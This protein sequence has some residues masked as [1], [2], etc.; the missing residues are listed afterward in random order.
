MVYAKIVYKFKTTIKRKSRT[1][2]NIFEE[3]VPNVDSQS[4]YNLNLNSVKLVKT[5]KKD[6]HKESMKGIHLLS[7]KILK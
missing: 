2:L 1:S 4:K 7:Q 3:N 6:I 5:I